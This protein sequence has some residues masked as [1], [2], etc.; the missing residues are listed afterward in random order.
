MVER[1]SRLRAAL[2]ARGLKLAREGSF[3]AVYNLRGEVVANV[4]RLH[5]VHRIA[6]RMGY[7]GREDRVRKAE[8]REALAAKGYK[9]RSGPAGLAIIDAK[10]QP[11]GDAMTIQQVETFLTRL[12]ACEAHREQGASDLYI[13]PTSP[14]PGRRAAPH[15]R[16]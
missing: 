8:A 10:G 5:E 16:K 14:P 7:R 4:L 2:A 11:V 15:L 6:C 9:L 3:Y 12:R 1:E 13:P